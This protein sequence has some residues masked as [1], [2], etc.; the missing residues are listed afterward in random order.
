MK[1]SARNLFKG[2][3][4]ELKQGAVN[5]VVK[6][7]IGGGNVITSM[8]TLGAVEDLGIGVGDEVTVVIKSSDVM[9]AK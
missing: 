8:V 4:T 5:S 7:D 6:V 9:L 1:L 2:K 3:V